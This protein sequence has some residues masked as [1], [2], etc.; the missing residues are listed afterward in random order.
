MCATNAMAGPFGL[1]MGMSLKEIGGKPKKIANG[2]Y[3]IVDIP[4]P[5]S[6]FESYIVQ[7]SPKSGLCWIKAISK[8]IATSA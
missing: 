1:N 4:K 6:A 5:H 7:V 8:D 3:E 2:K